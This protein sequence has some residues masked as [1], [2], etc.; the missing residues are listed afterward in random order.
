MEAWT[1]VLQQAGLTFKFLQ[2][3]LNRTL[4]TLFISVLTQ[5][6]KSREIGPHAELYPKENGSNEAL[7]LQRVQFP[8]PRVDG[9]L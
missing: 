5:E 7:P 3:L 6:A 9:R 1:E 2:E 8:G 4:Q